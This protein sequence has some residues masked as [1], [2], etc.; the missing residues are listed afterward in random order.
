VKKRTG[1]DAEL[2]DRAL[3]G[4]ER[5]L[6]EEAG[7]VGASR[8]GSSC[9]VSF[10]DRLSPEI[11]SPTTQRWK[12]VESWEA[13]RLEAT[14]SR[15]AGRWEEN[16]GGA[17]RRDLTAGLSRTSSGEVRSRGGAVADV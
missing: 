5:T 14:G 11:V 15:E 2:A 16:R 8:C 6:G 13:H 1:E 4:L 3:P 17:R 9:R 12:A 10:P 7:R